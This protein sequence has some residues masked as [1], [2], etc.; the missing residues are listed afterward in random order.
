M[1]GIAIA[2][3]TIESGTQMETGNGRNGL[4]AAQI[5][6]PNGNKRGGGGGGGEWKCADAEWNGNRET[7]IP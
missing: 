2:N 6:S 4:V 1:R 7:A 5:M 3:A